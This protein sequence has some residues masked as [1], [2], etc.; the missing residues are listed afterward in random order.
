[1]NL[2]CKGLYSTIL[3]ITQLYYLF[4]FGPMV[5]IH[6]AVLGVVIL[7]AGCAVLGVRLTGSKSQ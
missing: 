1:M 4:T 7:S 2:P 6:I 5:S 3:F